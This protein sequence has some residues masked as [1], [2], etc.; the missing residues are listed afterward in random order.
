MIN[1]DFD[2]FQELCKEIKATLK[3]ECLKVEEMFNKALYEEADDIEGD[4]ITKISLLNDVLVEFYRYELENGKSIRYCV[5]KSGVPRQWVLN[6]N[7]KGDASCVG[8]EL[9][10]LTHPLKQHCRHSWISLRHRS[11]FSPTVSS[12]FYYGKCEEKG[13]YCYKKS[14]K[15]CF[16]FQD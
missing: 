14:G 3:Q 11:K 12:E 4:F 13:P 5:E 15:Y 7:Q 9:T 16:R 8:T 6:D 10:F 1:F 2:C